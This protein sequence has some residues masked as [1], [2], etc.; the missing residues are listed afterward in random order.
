MNSENHALRFENKKD[1]L[2]QP[3]KIEESTGRLPPT[4]NDHNVANAVK[5][6]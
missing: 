2:H 5:A 1:C 6:M 3:K 4:P